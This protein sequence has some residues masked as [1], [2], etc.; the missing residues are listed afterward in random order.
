MFFR[1]FFEK[2]FSAFSRLLT[3][4]HSYLSESCDAES[5][6]FSERRESSVVVFLVIVPLVIV[7]GRDE[8]LVQIRPERLHVVNLGTKETRG[9][10]VYSHTR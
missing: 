1:L 9:S 10:V 8:S 2:P 4:L 6:R 7:H 3:F 5:F